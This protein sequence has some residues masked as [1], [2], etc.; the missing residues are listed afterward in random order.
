MAWW[1][2]ET[3][4]SSIYLLCGQN[5]CSYLDLLES[6]QFGHRV[7][8]KEC[9]G[10]NR[11]PTN[12]TFQYKRFSSLIGLQADESQF[13]R[14]GFFTGWSKQLR[15]RWQL[16]GCRNLDLKKTQLNTKHVL[17]FYWSLF[18]CLAFPC[19]VAKLVHICN[20]K[21][22]MPYVYCDKQFKPMYLPYWELHR[23][24]V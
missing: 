15:A 16:Q 8:N 3:T 11:F 23:C 19:A 9:V 18:S 20:S 4:Y 1:T 2:L 10:V 7:Q 12:I 6:C 22:A 14:V 13:K 21:T 24:N 17:L 5:N